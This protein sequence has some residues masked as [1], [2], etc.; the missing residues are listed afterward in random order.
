[1]KTNYFIKCI[2]LI[3]LS[4]MQMAQDIHFSQFMMTPMLLNP[5]LCGKSGGDYRG[6]ILHRNQWSSVTNN[7]FKTYGATYDMNF[8]SK[9]S[10][11]FLSGGINIFTDK[12]GASQLNTT[13][14]FLAAAYH[15][16]I[17]DNSYFS[18]G[19]NA[20]INQRSLNTNN[21]RFDNQFDGTGHNASL[22]HF[23]NLQN[24]NTTKPM[25]SAGISYSWTENSSVNVIS[26]NGFQGNK[27]NF[28]LSVHQFNRPNF[29]IIE[30][31]RLAM[32]Y[33][34]NFLASYGIPD[35][36]IAIQPSGYYAY[37]RK[38]QEFVIGSYIRYTLKEQSK[39]TQ[40]VK[41]SAVSL[42]AHYRVGDA[43]IPSLLVEMG[44]LS[45][46]IAYDVNTS[47]LKSVSRGMGGYEISLRYVS[48]NPFTGRRSKAR[49]Y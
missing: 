18:G 29:S 48:P 10:H 37:Q 16:R 22:S 4:K 7:P 44:S 17:D 2:L 38:A 45:L 30:S 20:G 1:M 12:A 11:N 33:V 47:G 23:E 5:S 40:L 6:V 27:F 35:F 13:I 39:Y 41:G 24:F 25:V 43:F 36:N 31:D 15:V 28:G 9:R 19:I 32:R 3:F 49:F 34:A 42:G 46:G 26:D 21:L 14:A 8:Y